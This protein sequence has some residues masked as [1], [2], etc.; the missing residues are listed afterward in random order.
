MIRFA[1]IRH[2]SR[3]PEALRQ[4][5]DQG[6]LALGK[7]AGGDKA[8]VAFIQTESFPGRQIFIRAVPCKVRQRR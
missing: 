6:A 5:F 3:R 1:E 4:P 2:G 7:P 8:P